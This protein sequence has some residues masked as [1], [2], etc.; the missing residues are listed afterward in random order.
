M[1]LISVSVSVPLFILSG[2]PLGLRHNPA[3]PSGKSRLPLLYEV[4]EL[5]SGNVEGGTGSPLETVTGVEPALMELQSIAF[6]LGYT[7]KVVYVL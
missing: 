2:V 7:V 6:P 3:S 5:A 4:S 1:C